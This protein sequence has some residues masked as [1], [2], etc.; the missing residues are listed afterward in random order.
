M[1]FPESA[2]TLSSGSVTSQPQV[3]NESDAFPTEKTAAAAAQI[4]EQGQGSTSTGTIDQFTPSS[5]CGSTPTIG[6]RDPLAIQLAPTATSALDTESI[7]NLCAQFVVDKII[8]F[9]IGSGITPADLIKELDLLTGNALFMVKPSTTSGTSPFGET[10]FFTLCVRLYFAHFQS[11]WPLACPE[12]FHPSSV[13][14]PLYLAV[15]I[16][17]AMYG[18]EDLVLFG[19][20]LHEAFRARLITRSMD[21]KVPNQPSYDSCLTLLLNQIAALYFGHKRSFYVAQQL[22]VSLHTQARRLGLFDED[23]WPSPTASK[24][25][26]PVC[27]KS[28]SYRRLALGIYRVDVYVALLLGTRPIVSPQE[29]RIS[30]LPQETWQCDSGRDDN[31]KRNGI[32]VAQPQYY[33]DLIETVLDADDSLPALHALDLELVLM[34]IAHETWRIDQER[35]VFHR[36]YGEHHCV[37]EVVRSYDRGISLDTKSASSV[38]TLGHIRPALAPTRRHW[39]ACVSSLRKWSVAFTATLRSPSLRQD[40]SRIL[41]CRILYHLLLLQT[42]SSINT[43]ANSA[44]LPDAVIPAKIV[45]WLKSEDC[46]EAL[47]HATS[48]Y[49]LVSE[50]MQAVVTERANFNLLTFGELTLLFPHI[51]ESVCQLSKCYVFL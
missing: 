32:A 15:C 44:H 9:E 23:Q 28:E 42:Y 21:L 48:L 18:E 31:L 8:T 33:T 14:P 19:R 27:S 51:A 4:I 10:P 38:R 5:G 39:S 47:Q 12:H 17:G 40:R 24:W 3:D 45:I 13:S 6:Q 1:L 20:S 30:T 7:T 22:G 41:S 46:M 37:A 34:G 36:L 35:F 43:L 29:L 16:I 49:T 25:E 11:L 26:R 2:T 50:E